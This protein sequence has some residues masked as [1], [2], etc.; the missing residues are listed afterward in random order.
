MTSNTCQ[1]GYDTE[2]DA[3]RIIVLETKLA[4][5]QAALLALVKANC[6]CYD[7]TRQSLILPASEGLEQQVYLALLTEAPGA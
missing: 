1:H 2:C 6:A 7:G 4:Q 3:C 5:V